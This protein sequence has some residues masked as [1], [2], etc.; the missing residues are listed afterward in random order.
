MCFVCVHVCVRICM[1]VIVY[2]VYMSSV[3]SEIYRVSAVWTCEK[4]L[5]Q[6]IT[7]LFNIS[8]INYNHNADFTALAS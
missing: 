5:T 3:H 2:S 4:K 7:K 8:I 6:Q 1:Y